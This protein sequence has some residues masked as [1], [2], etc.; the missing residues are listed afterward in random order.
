MGTDLPAEA[1]IKLADHPNILIDKEAMG[2]ANQIS[3]I[4]AAPTFLIILA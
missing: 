2:R 4:L 1:I 3:K